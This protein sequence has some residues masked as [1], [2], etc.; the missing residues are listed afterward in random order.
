MSFDSAC[1]IAVVFT[2]G[3]I[4]IAISAN[5]SPQ[6][7]GRMLPQQ[8]PPFD[9]DCAYILASAVYKQLYIETIRPDLA[10][11][12][13]MESLC[14][15]PIEQDRVAL[16]IISNTT[17]EAFDAA[18]SV[19]FASWGSGL[20]YYPGDYSAMQVRNG[21]MWLHG[22]DGV[23]ELLNA[24][25]MCCG[26]FCLPADPPNSRTPLTVLPRHSVAGCT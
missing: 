11:L 12:N 10:F 3:L 20:V 17:I 2:A 13:F 1:L 25:G 24:V 26:A 6:G 5:A 4:T 18:G 8:P 15:L 14:S 22:Q 21:R 23:S 19:L 16:P 7:G 9:D